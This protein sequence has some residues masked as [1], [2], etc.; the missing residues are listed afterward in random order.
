MSAS[1]E[2]GNTG[3]IDGELRCPCMAKTS[4]NAW[5]HLK[6]PC[7]LGGPEAVALK[8][9]DARVPPRPKVS[10]KHTIDWGRLSLGGFAMHR[11]GL[12]CCPYCGSSEIYASEP[13]TLWQRISIVFLLRLVRCH[14]CMH[15]H[16]RPIIYPPPNPALR[17]GLRKKSHTASSE[18]SVK[19]DRSA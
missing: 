8:K 1:R 13:R 2:L 5:Q 3:S 17:G 11:I 15:R 12:T 6:S 7:K 4:F 10:G 18:N 19:K 14:A 16:Y 9:T